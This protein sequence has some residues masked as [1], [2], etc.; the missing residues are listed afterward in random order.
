MHLNRVYPVSSKEPVLVVH[1]KCHTK[2]KPLLSSRIDTDMYFSGQHFLK[3][4]NPSD[5]LLV[6]PAALCTVTNRTMPCW[7]IY[8]WYEIKLKCLHHSWPIQL[9]KMNTNQHNEIKKCTNLSVCIRADYSLQV[10]I[11][12]FLK[13]T[14]VFSGC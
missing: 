7:S 12:L 11:D 4:K 14:P 8:L 1:M 6:V 9:Q 5:L 13:E 2:P 10:L 3:L